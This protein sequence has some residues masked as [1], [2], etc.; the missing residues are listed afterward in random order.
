MG[1]FVPHTLAPGTI[2]AGYGYKPSNRG[3]PEEWAVIPR[4]HSR[5]DILSL[6]TVIGGVTVD[7]HKNRPP[8]FRTHPYG[9]FSPPAM[10]IG[11]ATAD[12]QIHV[13]S[14]P[15]GTHTGNSCR[16]PQ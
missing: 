4:T 6:F 15:A 7:G 3:R 13:P 2:V 14:H 1:R 12:G 10:V 5:W 9:D 16:R 11:G 8:V